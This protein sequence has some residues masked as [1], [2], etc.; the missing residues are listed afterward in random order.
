M[1][2]LIDV[3][4]N[5]FPSGITRNASAA[6]TGGTINGVTSI[7][8]AT[9]NPG[10]LAS[11]ANDLV[12]GDGSG[13]FGATIYSNA[14]N[15]GNIYFADGT[16][17]DTLYAGFIQY[18]HG[19]NFLRFG[20]NGAEKVRITSGGEV[21]MGINTP[22]NQL[23]VHRNTTAGSFA[24]FTNTTTGTTS[25][26]GIIVGIDSSNA[27]LYSYEN[28]PLYLGTNGLGRIRIDGGGDVNIIRT[29]NP[30]LLLNNNDTSSTWDYNDVYSTLDFHTQSTAHPYT[31]GPNASI[32]AVHTR[33]GTSHTYAD[34][35]LVF[36]TLDEGGSTGVEERMRITQD[37][38]LLI[39]TTTSTGAQLNVYKEAYNT[40][41][42][43]FILEHR[44]YATSTGTVYN[45]AAQINMRSKIDTGITDSGHRAALYVNN[46]RNWGITGDAGSLTQ[47]YCGLFQY[48][49]LSE[50]GSSPVTSNAR[51]V[52]ISPT[53]NSGTITSMVDLYLTAPSVSG[54]TVTNHW[55]IFQAGPTSD[56]SN[57]FNG[58]VGFG[59]NLPSTYRV[60]LHEPNAANN[61][62]H[63]TNATTGS[64]SGDGFVFG[65]ATDGTVYL[66]NYESTHARFGTNNGMR[67]T[68]VSGGGVVI[69]AGT[70]A[71]GMLS[72]EGVTALQETT[73][74]SQTSGWGKLYVKSSDSKLYFMDDSG[75]E[76]DL[77]AGGGSSIPVQDEGSAVLTASTLNFVG[78][79]VTATDGGSGVATITIPGGGGSGGFSYTHK[80]ANYTA[81]AGDGIRVDSSGGTA[82]TI[83][84]PS[85]PSD[86]DEVLVMDVGGMV[87]TYVVDV[88]GNGKDIVGSSDNFDVDVN[89]GSAIFVFDS[90][91]DQWGVR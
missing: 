90:T 44:H 1:V 42:Y 70:T 65:N 35:G 86:G 71:A 54:G 83:T 11:D 6:I 38:N 23:H 29:A 13:D 75:N 40:A 64:T 66:Y 53:C 46:F 30:T 76:T 82:F 85:S 45:N 22:A 48:G 52:Q 88:D 34:A 37:G 84:L 12:I 51:G 91:T 36:L 79:G 89:Y 16:S 4:L 50:D 72:V 56:T 73:A 69:G 14:A 81:S 19:S 47:M 55:G 18:N 87:E 24:R 67:L 31:P 61:Y 3:P 78:A 21:G 41:Q 59:I 39:G 27:Y 63:F 9:S 10:D 5:Q 60:Q 20:T 77:L 74:P 8:V 49:H 68:L 7:G 2:E 28:T 25:S 32:R 58:K 62:M 17:G 43:G 26:D 57:F 33:T 15:N 80:T